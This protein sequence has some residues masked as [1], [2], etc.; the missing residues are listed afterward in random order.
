[1]LWAID[2]GNTCT[3]SGFMVGRKV[4]VRSNAPTEQLKTKKGAVKWARQLRRLGSAE[5]FVVGSVVPAV[6]E[7]LEAAIRSLFEARVLWVKPDMELGMSLKVKKIEEVGADRVVNALAARSL[8]GFPCIVVDF[9]TATTFDVVDRHGN[10]IGGAILPG[11]KTGFRAMHSFTAKLPDLEFKLARTAIGRSTAEAMR[12]G[13]YFGAIGQIRELLL[14]IRKELG[15]VAPAIATG[16]FCRSFKEEGI[17]D[18]VV[19]DLT[20]QGLTLV[21]NRFHA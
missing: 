8:F 20:L 12:S 15:V 16:G 11:I 7:P 4:S 10:Y 6:D 2:V 18:H 1:M 19:P 21:W 3:T 9:G 14:R 5:G 13:V 17:F